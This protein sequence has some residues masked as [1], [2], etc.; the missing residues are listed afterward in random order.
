MITQF[1]TIPKS[2]LK[3]LLE[4]LVVSSFCPDFLAE[5]VNLGFLNDNLGCGVVESRNEYE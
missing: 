3:G 4:L 5:T 1:R 2:K